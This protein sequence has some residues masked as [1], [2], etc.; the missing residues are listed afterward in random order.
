MDAPILNLFRFLF[1]PTSLVSVVSRTIIVIGLITG[2]VYLTAVFMVDDPLQRTWQATMVLIPT[3]LFFIFGAFILVTNLNRTRTELEKT[4]MSDRLTGLA[5]RH[6]ATQFLDAQEGLAG[7]AVMVDIDHFKRIN[8]TYGH[9]AGDK[10]IRDLADH[11]RKNNRRTDLVCRYGGEEFL[12][13]LRNADADAV[14]ARAEELRDQFAQREFVI[15]G[16]S[17]TIT[18][19]VGIAQKL[20][21]EPISQTLLRADRALY[22]SKRGGRNRTTLYRHEKLGLGTAA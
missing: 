1:G 17:V 21:D 6:F 11:L 22:A 9:L 19:S 2:G 13:F 16:Q 18:A 20:P 3:E 10:V 8:D 5:N 15:G 7:V 14:Y 12:I 4:A